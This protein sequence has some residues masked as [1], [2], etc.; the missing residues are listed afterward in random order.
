MA[1]SKTV[2]LISK[3]GNEIPKTKEEADALIKWCKKSGHENW[4]KIKEKA[5]SSKDED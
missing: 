4:W 3:E 5:T 1:K 2:I